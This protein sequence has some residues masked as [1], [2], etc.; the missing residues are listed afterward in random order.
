MIIIVRGYKPAAI[1]LAI[2]SLLILIVGIKGEM[3]WINNTNPVDSILYALLTIIP[4]ILSIIFDVIIS[5]HF[6][7]VKTVNNTENLGI[8][9]T[10]K[11]L[12]CHD[13][14][15]GLRYVPEIYINKFSIY[16]SVRPSPCPV[17]VAGPITQIHP[18]FRPMLHK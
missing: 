12:I 13:G 10:Q 14:N 4:L 3:A 9:L 15:V 2:L 8:W 11:Y 17:P 7:K 1:A 18:F 6:T 16:T 5:R